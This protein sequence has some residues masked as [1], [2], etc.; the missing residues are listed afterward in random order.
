MTQTQ[1][2]RLEQ[3]E[4]ILAGAETPDPKSFQELIAHTAR[5]YRLVLTRMEQYACTRLQ[6]EMSTLCSRVFHREW[7]DGWEHLL[8]TRLT[9]FREASALQAE[10]PERAQEITAADLQLLDDLVKDANSWC[11]VSDT[12]VGEDRTIERVDLDTWHALHRAWNNRSK[13]ISRK[14]FFRS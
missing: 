5:D 3:L 8:W 7:I 2:E 10:E 11:K 1:H 6:D 9:A 13:R 12:S 14:S 4:R